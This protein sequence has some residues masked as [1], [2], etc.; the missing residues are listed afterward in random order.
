MDLARGWSGEFSGLVSSISFPISVVV[1]FAL[2][3]L[4]SGSSQGMSV[5]LE[6]ACNVLLGSHDALAAPPSHFP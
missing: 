3:A 4:V 5:T 1:F 6:I 2:V